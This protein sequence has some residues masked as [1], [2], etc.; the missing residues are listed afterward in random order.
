MTNELFNNSLSKSIAGFTTNS[1]YNKHILDAV[2][3]TATIGHRKNK[4][5]LHFRRDSL[6]P[7]IEERKTIISDYLTLGIGKVDLVKL[8]LKVAQPAVDDD[9]SLEKSAW[10]V[11]QAEKIQSMRFNPKES[12]ESVRVLSGGDTSHHA[13]P[14]VIRM[15]LPNGKLATTDAEKASVLGP[16]FHRVLNNHRP[17]YWPVL[18][19]IKQR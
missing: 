17:I 3:N 2:T 1:K 10:S 15:R 4:G 11:H 5:W 12:W 14:T 19:K 7:L 9:I 6:L 8:Q 18:D 13:S 16:H